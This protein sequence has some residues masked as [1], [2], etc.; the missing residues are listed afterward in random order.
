VLVEKEW[1]SFGHMFRT[2]CT[3]EGYK[4]QESSPVFTQWLDAVWQV[5]RQMP[6]EFEFGEALLSLLAAEVLPDNA[7]GTL[8]FDNAAE[9]A[10]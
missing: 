10:R 1:V 5:T 7:F 2:R 3:K 4:G 6:C 9:R 8:V